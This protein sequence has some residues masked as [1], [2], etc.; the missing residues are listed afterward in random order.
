MVTKEVN[1]MRKLVLHLVAVLG[2][3]GMAAASASAAPSLNGIDA[4][5]AHRPEI[6]QA[7]YYWHHRHYEHRHWEHTHGRYY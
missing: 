1:T 2:V 6:V 4:A 5:Q 7:A 3:M